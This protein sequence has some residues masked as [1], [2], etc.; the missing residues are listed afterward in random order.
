[1]T[2]YLL[3]GGVALGLIAVAWAVNY[4]FAKMVDYMLDGHGE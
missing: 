1:M 3:I 2:A 4:L